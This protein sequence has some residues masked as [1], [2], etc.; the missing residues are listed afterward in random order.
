MPEMLRALRVRLVAGLALALLV[1]AA[2]A[3]GAATMWGLGID[4]GSIGGPY[5]VPRIAVTNEST[6]GERISLFAISIGD[7]QNYIFDAVLG[8]GSSPSASGDLLASEA[9]TGATLAHGNR[10]NDQRG[11]WAVVWTFSDFDPTESLLFEVDVDP[12]VGG[13]IVDARDAFFGGATNAVAAVLFEDGSWETHTLTDMSYS[14]SSNPTDPF[15]PPGA[16]VPEP[17]A[18]LLFAVGFGLVGLRRRR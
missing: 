10:V 9:L 18:A 13:P 17:G 11:G 14:S 12:R 2:S 1:T 3:A 8:A 5:N 15:T 6:A 7:S 16:A 4:P